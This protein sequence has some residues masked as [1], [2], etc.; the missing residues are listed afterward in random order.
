MVVANATDAVLEISRE[1]IG[2]GNGGWERHALVGG[3]TSIL[4][5]NTTTFE[6]GVREVEILSP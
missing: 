2:F 3:T 5:L 1:M 4:D 6:V